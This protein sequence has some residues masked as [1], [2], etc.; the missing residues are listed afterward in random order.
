MH[1]L[2][3]RSGEVQLDLIDVAP[4][5]VLARL[6]RL[7]DWMFRA[8]E[9]LRGVLVFRRVTATNVTAFQTKAQ[10]YPAI[11]RLQALLA[12]PCV[13]SDLLNLVEMFTGLHGVSPWRSC[14]TEENVRRVDTERTDKFD[15]LAP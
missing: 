6:K 5:P 8:M 2:V 1:N 4:A 15:V 12:S 14:P 11:T 3:P 10:V 7:H 9:M 13:R